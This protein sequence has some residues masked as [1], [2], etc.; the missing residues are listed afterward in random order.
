MPAFA[1]F[2]MR[3]IQSLL[4]LLAVSFVGYG[5]ISLMPGD[6]IDM[7][8]AGNPYAGPDDVARLKQAYGLDKPMV[9]RYGLWLSH[10]MQGDWG[11]SR[12]Y[13]AP[14]GDLLWPALVQSLILIGTS[15]A[16]ALMLAIPLGVWAAYRYNTSVDHIINFLCFAGLSVPSFWA[17]IVAITLFSV[18]FN[19]LPAGGMGTPLHYVAPVLILTL[20]TVGHYIR[21]VRGTMIEVLQENYIQTAR[22]KGLKPSYVVI[23]HAF[24]NAAIPLVTVV[25]LDFGGLFSGA[26]ITETIFSIQGMGKLIY[27]SIMGNDYNLAMMGLMVT[28]IAVLLGNIV[29]DGLQ[30][31]LDPRVNTDNK[32]GA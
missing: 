18:T 1:S 7:L 25:A 15:M 12:L 9:E 6:P 14:V 2:L 29:A 17:A 23:H 26:L 30:K 28:T 24:K 21:Y 27:D 4:V 11:Y 19:I 10:V 5:L 8:V 32:G 22:A 20:A 13:A 3:I 31:T 16:L